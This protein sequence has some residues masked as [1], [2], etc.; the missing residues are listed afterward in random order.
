MKVRIILALVDLLCDKL[1][2]FGA[3]KFNDD[4]GRSIIKAARD[5]QAYLHDKLEKYKEPKEF[6]NHVVVIEKHQDK[7]ATKYY[8]HSNSWNSITENFCQTESEIYNNVDRLFDGILFRMAYPKEDS[9]LLSNTPKYKEMLEAARFKGQDTPSRFDFYKENIHSLLV[10]AFEGGS[11]Y[12]YFISESNKD[13][14][15]CRFDEVA[16]Q[17]GGFFI[18][19]DKEEWDGEK[20]VNND[21]TVKVDR[22]K[23]E[24]GFEIFEKNHKKHFA[25]FVSENDDATTADVYLQ[26]VCFGEIIFG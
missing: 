15:N 14:Y 25:D 21:L 4:D 20:F 1:V 26:C 17:D 16:F 9:S 11:N 10:S 13:K 23:L 18:I 24:K 12:W 8:V 19:G 5:F 6:D 7:N 2:T 3:S 22:A